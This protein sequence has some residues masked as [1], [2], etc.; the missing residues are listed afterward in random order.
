MTRKL[1]LSFAIL[2]ASAIAS[3][4]SFSVTLFQPSIVGGS[5]LQPGEYK[6]ELNESK[7]V[8]RGGKSSAQ[9]DVRVETGDQ[10][11]SSTSVRY[12]NGDGKYR[13]QEIR[14]GGTKTKLVFN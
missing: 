7:V 4:K 8:I 5:E 11:F 2:A 10:K 12:Q 14:L 13:V 1:L 9:A 3:A 6:L